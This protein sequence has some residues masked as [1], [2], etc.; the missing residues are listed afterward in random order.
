MSSNLMWAPVVPP[1]GHDLCSETKFIL[2]KHYQEPINDTLRA[3]DV[4]YLRGVKD[5]AALSRVRKD[6]Q[7]LIDAI[8]KHGEI[9]LKEHF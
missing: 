2:R 3:M 5:G 8:N 7:T 6:M 9:E 4:N 1:D